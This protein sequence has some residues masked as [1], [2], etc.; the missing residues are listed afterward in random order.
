MSAPTNITYTARFDATLEA[1]IS[2]LSAIY[3]LCLSSHANR[4]AAGETSTNGDDATKGS[5]C[6]RARTIIQESN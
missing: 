4:N 3:K 6:D 5:N 1:E 2:A